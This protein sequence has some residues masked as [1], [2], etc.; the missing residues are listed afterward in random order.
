MEG[1]IDWKA[2]MYERLSR[3]QRIELA[4]DL[5]DSVASEHG[6]QP[7]SEEQ[8]KELLRRVDELDG[9]RMQTHA[10]S[11]VKQRLLREVL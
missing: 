2:E 6:P 4:M 3:A 1:N 8:R 9:G 7:V 5:W 11:D 10:W